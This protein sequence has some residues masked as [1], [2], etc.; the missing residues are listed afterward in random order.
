MNNKI[1]I[2]LGNGLN[3]VA[4]QNPDSAYDKEIFIDV[5]SESGMCYQSLAIVRPTYHY[6]DDKVVYNFDKF[7]VLVFGDAE[8]NNVTDEFTVPLYVDNE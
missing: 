1:V 5:E 8:Q 7:N 4:E 2:P 3:L 6:E